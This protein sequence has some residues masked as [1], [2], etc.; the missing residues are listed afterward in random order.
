VQHQDA[1]GCEHPEKFLHSCLFVRYVHEDVLAQHRIKGVIIPGHIQDGACLKP[2]FFRK[3]GPPG[4]HLC[5]INIGGGQID[6][7]DPASKGGC[8]QP[9]RSPQAAAGIQDMKIRG[10]AKIIHQRQ[11]GPHTAGMELVHQRQIFGMKRFGVNACRSQAGSNVVYQIR[12]IIMVAQAGF[13][14]KNLTMC[15]VK[16]LDV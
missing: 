11:G 9:G 7:R 16:G 6:S 2:H 15:A 4:Q 3:T 13:H 12:G 1:A 5:C 10:D 14:G 8:Q